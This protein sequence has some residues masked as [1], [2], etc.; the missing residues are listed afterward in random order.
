VIAHAYIVPVLF[1][2]LLGIVI[3]ESG[4]PV[5]SDYCPICA[6]RCECKKCSRRLSSVAADFKSACIG[7]GVPPDQASFDFKL[8]ISSAKNA[9]AVNER[10]RSSKRKPY[11]AIREIEPAMATVPKVPVSDFPRE[12]CGGLDVNPGTSEDYRT[13]YTAEGSFLRDDVPVP[14][15]AKLP[16]SA[17]QVNGV[18]EDGNV[19]YCH[20][21]KKHGNLLCCDFCPRA[22]HP[23]CVTADEPCGEGPWE[24]FVCRQEKVAEDDVVTGQSSLDLVCASFVD[25]KHSEDIATCVQVLDLIHETILKLVDYDFGIL[26]RQPVDC[27]AIPAYSA[28]VKNPMD[29]GT[30]ATKI[31]NGEY[32]EKYREN[33]CWDDVLVAVLRDIELVWHNC[34][35]FNF[36]GSSIYRMAEVQRRKYMRIR[37]RSFDFLLSSEAKQRVDAYVSECELERSKVARAPMP[38]TADRRSNGRHKITIG[39]SKKNNKIVAVLDPDTGLLVKMYSSFKGA[40]LA[41]RF[42]VGLGHPVEYPS[43]SEYFFGKLVPTMT[44]D[45]SLRLFGYRWLYMEDL[46][47]GKVMFGTPEASGLGATSLDTVEVK[48]GNNSYAFLSIEE[49]ASWA[50]LPAEVSV[51]E[52][53]RKLSEMPYGEWTTIGGLSWRK[54][55]QKGQQKDVPT[56]GVHSQI[57]RPGENG[58]ASLADKCLIV[59]VSKHPFPTN[60]AFVKEDLIT[61]RALIGFESASAAHEDWLTTRENSP[62]C[63]VDEPTEFR[64]FAAYYLD[65]ERNIDGIIWRT[66][67]EPGP[68]LDASTL[69]TAAQESVAKS[70]VQERP[71]SKSAES[72]ET[73]T[74]GTSGSVGA[75]NGLAHANGNAPVGVAEL[76]SVLQGAPAESEKATALNLFKKTS[77]HQ[78]SLRE[79]LNAN[80]DL[81]GAKRTHENDT[82]GA[83]R[84][85]KKAAVCYT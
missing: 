10:R 84:A 71:A 56:P 1:Q 39:R 61:R 4:V 35:T 42:L 17:P 40:K 53:R 5:S 83:C 18:Q 51:A 31:V 8:S 74:E 79:A 22:F 50:N 28:I 23:D 38:S 16:A 45:P 72:Q 52:I 47:N 62:V 33:L 81:I 70:S 34:F 65:G 32:A 49:A 82:L 64:Y 60:V 9:E 54:L 85:S 24:C 55:E 12:V 29:L 19:D 57:P 43:F 6:L 68:D 30:I 36:E 63:P 80:G 41:A 14:E 27:E 58:D 13:V 44:E 73:R 46:V 37:K 11:A 67:R 75:E 69:S 21:C 76:P 59:D 20:T 2:S 25:F 66:L 48:I 7:Q 78:C 77:G 15:D 26:F 3:D